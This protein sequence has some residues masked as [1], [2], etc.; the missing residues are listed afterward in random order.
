[1][2]KSLKSAFVV[3]TVLGSLAVLPSSALADGGISVFSGGAS[4][5]CKTIN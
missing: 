1:M 2:R 5:C 4:G 3:L